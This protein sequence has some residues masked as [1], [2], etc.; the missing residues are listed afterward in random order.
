ME[1]NLSF[2][3]NGKQP[4]MEDDLKKVHPKQSKVKT[5]VVAPFRVT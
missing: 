3:A 1:Y 2:F 5:M 4:K